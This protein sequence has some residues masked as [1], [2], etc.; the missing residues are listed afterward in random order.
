MT[1]S[2]IIPR[3]LSALLAAWLRSR[4]RAVRSCAL[5]S[6]AF[7][8]FGS[9]IV[10]CALSSESPAIPDDRTAVRAAGAGAGASSTARKGVDAPAPVASNNESNAADEAAKAA[11][12]L[13]PPSPVTGGLDSAPSEAVASVDNIYRSHFERA[14]REIKLEDA[15]ERLRELEREVDEER[16]KL[17]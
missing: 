13:S 17:E 3:R 6:L 12:A 7:A 9:G 14:Q 5:A 11:D 16:R 1:S 2:H 15:Y 10:A 8:W 4:R